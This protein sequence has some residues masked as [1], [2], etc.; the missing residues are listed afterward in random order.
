LDSLSH[1][2]AY[3]K[4]CEKSLC[5]IMFYFVI[6]NTNLIH[7]SLFHFIEVH[8]LDIF[9]ALLAHLQEALHTTWANNAPKHVET[10]NLNK[11]KK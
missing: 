4:T 7:I 8:S 3:I 9:R 2:Q 1:Y 6:S 5:N 10:V 11:V